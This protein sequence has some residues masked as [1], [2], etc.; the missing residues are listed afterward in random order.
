MKDSAIGYEDCV[1]TVCATP[2]GINL[3]VPPIVP[4][5]LFIW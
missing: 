2:L 1:I 5:L 4:S 3:G